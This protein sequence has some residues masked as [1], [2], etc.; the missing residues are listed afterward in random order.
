MIAM[1]LPEKTVRNLLDYI[2]EYLDHACSQ[3]FI[4][5]AEQ[6]KMRIKRAIGRAEGRPRSMMNDFRVERLIGREV[7]R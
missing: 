4:R 5:E 7:S 1:N 3:K 6:D 2:N